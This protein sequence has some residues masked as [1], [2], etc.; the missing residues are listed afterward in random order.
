M[1]WQA[2]FAGKRLSGDSRQSI[3]CIIDSR[4][5]GLIGDFTV[6]LDHG[7]F[8]RQ[9]HLDRAA[10][11]AIRQAGPFPPPPGGGAGRY[12]IYGTAIFID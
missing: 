10:E 9:I 8:A 5:E 4:A 6:C 7:A 3:A 2:I 11:Q 1:V 12:T